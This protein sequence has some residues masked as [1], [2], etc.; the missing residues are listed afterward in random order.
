VSDRYQT[1]W[2]S[3]RLFW[4]Q[5]IYFGVTGLWPLVH[6]R[7]F[8]LVTG[9]KQDDWLV[10]TVGLLILVI[11]VALCVS[12]RARVLNAGNYVVAAG[13]AFALMLVD[14]V[15]TANGAISPIYLLDAAAECFLLIAWATV[16]YL[17]YRNR[18]GMDRRHEGHL[19]MALR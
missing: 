18:R 10:E 11:G 3:R 16:A 9:P 19:A 2:I 7:S 1:Y 12:A 13:S 6:L 8:E 5:G 17:A 14:I 15:F 4:V